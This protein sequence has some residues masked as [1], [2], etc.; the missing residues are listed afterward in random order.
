MRGTFAARVLAAVARIPRGRVATYGQIAALCGSPRAAR[1]VGWI[2]RHAT[3]APRP[4]AS[5]SLGEGWQRVIN[6]EGRLSI[7]HAVLTPAMQATLLRREGVP[8]RKRRSTYRVDLQRYLWKPERT[9]KRGRAG[10][11]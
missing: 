7:V 6:R 5:R 8:T 4:K 10:F 2:L 3:A 1:Q 11:V 9:Q